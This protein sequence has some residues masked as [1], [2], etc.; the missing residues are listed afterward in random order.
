MSLYLDASV[1]VALIIADI[2]SARA[3]ALLAQHRSLVVV[4]DFAAAELAS[5]LAR[6]LRMG[7]LTPDE[8]RTALTDFDA[9]ASTTA[10]RA[11]IR[12]ADVGFADGLLRRFDQPLR[13]PDALHLAVAFRIGATL[14]T[15]DTRMAT[16][17]R[18]IGINVLPA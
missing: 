2:H 12:T 1:V 6:R 5:T 4:S 18:A 9:W 14:A 7:L 16:A 8:A 13:T 10:R 11:S 3:E 15:F 17:A